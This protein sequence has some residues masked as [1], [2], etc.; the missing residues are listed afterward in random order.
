MD[1]WMNG[2]EEGVRGW[3][4]GR[5]SRWLGEGR[6]AWRRRGEVSLVGERRGQAVELVEPAELESGLER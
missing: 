4:R 6:G 3:R 2:R 1:A 5:G